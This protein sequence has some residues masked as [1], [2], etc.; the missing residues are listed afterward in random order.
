MTAILIGPFDRHYCGRL[1]LIDM[2]NMEI[3]NANNVKN[4]TISSVYKYL[5][6]ILSR[7][8]LKVFFTYASSY[9]LKG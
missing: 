9:C 3:A 8:D 7:V 2:I 6:K 5:N 1:Y 4:I